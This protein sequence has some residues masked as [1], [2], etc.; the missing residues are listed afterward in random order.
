[1]KKIAN[2]LAAFVSSLALS[3]APTL[4][5]AQQFQ[6]QTTIQNQIGSDPFLR[7]ESFPGPTVQGIFT[8][9]NNGEIAQS[10]ALPLNSGTHLG[11]VS[12]GNMFPATSIAQQAIMSRWPQYMKATASGKLAFVF[13][14]VYMNGSLVE[15]GGGANLVCTGS[16]EYPVG[17]FQQMTTNNGA[18]TSITVASGAVGVSDFF[19]NPPPN[20]AGYFTRVYCTTSGAGVTP[21]KA[22]QGSPP[23]AGSS[24]S[25]PTDQTLSGTVL[26]AYPYTGSPQTTQY[27]YAPIVIGQTNARQFCLWGDSRSS[28][29][30]DDFDGQVVEGGMPE[31]SIGAIAPTLNLAVGG[32]RQS[33]FNASH[34]TRLALGLA[35]CTDH[36]NAYG[37]N[38]LGSGQT[39]AQLEASFATFLGYFPATSKVSIATMPPYTT[40]SNAAI[41]SVTYSGLIETVTLTNTGSNFAPTT[42]LFVGELVTLAGA[43]PTS[44]NGNCVVQTIT[45]GTAFTCSNPTSTGTGTA[46]GTITMGTAWQDTFNQ[47]PALGNDSYRTAFND[48]CRFTAPSLGFYKCFDIASIAE[49][50]YDS[51]IWVVY[52]N[53]GGKQATTQDGLHMS[54]IEYLKLYKSGLISAQTLY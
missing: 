26:N 31:R 41:T 47:S 23:G 30:N 1:M 33:Y 34:S 14:N 43:T 13:P 45:S 20:G 29:Q 4:A 36:F 21:V 24:Y 38:D 49:S 22:M 7:G 44:E 11:V 9:L 39:A 54:Y 17:V 52:N 2:R 32:D 53:A 28:G 19:A 35:Y 15:T 12:E 48:W 5:L 18:S 51:G 37:I 25:S 6:L 40:A 27:F 10:G 8:N 16:L 50:A 46:T 3:F 42:Y